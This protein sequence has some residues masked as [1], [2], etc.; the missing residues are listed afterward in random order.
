[1]LAFS[2][3]LQ[4]RGLPTK[5]TS[6]NDVDV[7]MSAFHEELKTLNLWQYYVLDGVKQKADVR[8]VLDAGTGSPWQGESVAGKTVVE[9]ANL[10]RS[11]G[12]LDESKKFHDRFSVTVKPEIAASLVK[13]AF[14]ELSDSDALASAWQ[15]VVDVLN[16]PLYEEWENDTSSALEQMKGRVKYTR[17]EDNGPKLGEIT[18]E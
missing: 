17:L 5:I 12:A 2:A 6:G 11:S 13:A 9:L 14:T 10:I 18:K 15:K 4:A 1:M 3:S 7:L 8:T 16:V